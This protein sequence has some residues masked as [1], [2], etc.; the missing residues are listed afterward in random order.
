MLHAPALEASP[1]CRVKE[2]LVAFAEPALP[3][4]PPRACCVDGVSTAVMALSAASLLTCLVL[5]EAPAGPAESWV[6][7]RG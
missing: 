4:A 2:G 5:H 7:V 1:V 6:G 3:V